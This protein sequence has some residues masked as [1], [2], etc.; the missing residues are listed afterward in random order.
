MPQRLWERLAAPASAL[1]PTSQERVCVCVAAGGAG[2]CQAQHSRGNLRAIL[3][4]KI[5]SMLGT[6]LMIPMHHS[7]R[8][9]L[10]IPTLNPKCI[11]SNKP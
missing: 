8:P 7:R 2:I 3:R 11:S 4:Q 5:C 9:R 1:T 6:L 10:P